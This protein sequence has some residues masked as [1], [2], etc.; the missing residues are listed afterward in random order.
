LQA[1]P[2]LISEPGSVTDTHKV[3]LR[4]LGAYPRLAHRLENI[5]P[6]WSDLAHTPMVRIKAH[7][8]TEGRGLMAEGFL[9][10]EKKRK[11]P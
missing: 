1:L 2:R 6:G 8:D 9:K 11:Y 5:I 4:S 10:I 3:G 7:I